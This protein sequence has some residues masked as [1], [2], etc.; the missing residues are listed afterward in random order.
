MWG[1]YGR[2][3]YTR[4]HAIDYILVI[5]H[6]GKS[7]L[8]TSRGITSLL[9]GISFYSG[10]IY[11]YLRLPEFFYLSFYTEKMYS[12]FER[13]RVI[14]TRFVVPKIN[15]RTVTHVWLAITETIKAVRRRSRKIRRR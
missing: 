9:V 15:M 11:Q 8:K 6:A 2:T 10:K 7:M 5:F 14:G 12:T 1:P 3:P 4:S 13:L